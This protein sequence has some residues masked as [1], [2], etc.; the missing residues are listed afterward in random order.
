MWFQNRRARTLK[1]KGAKKVLWQSDSPVHSAFP[2]NRGPHAGP[3][4]LQPQGPPPSYSAQVKQEMDE[5]GY[6][7]QRP[8][9]YSTSEEQQQY[10]SMYRLASSTTPPLTGYWSQPSSQTPPAPTLWCH[11][12]MEM[13]NYSSSS[14]QPPAFMY[15]GPAEQQMY[16]STSSHTSTPDTPDSGYWDA[17]LENSPLME[18][19]Y[20]QLEDSW[21][22]GHAAFVQH[23]PLPELSLQEILGELDEGWLGGE[24][25]VEK[26][27]LC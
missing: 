15:P 27:A 9:S 12:P 4:P 26:A 20:S 10:G 7:G 3:V 1:C 19:Q 22:S 16:M 2:P 25:L 23:A 5:A 18:G 6:Y 11:S 13:R 24:G 17:S 21:E 14:N 8:P